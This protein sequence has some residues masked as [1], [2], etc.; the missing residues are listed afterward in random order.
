[1]QYIIEDEGEAQ[2]S[3]FEC[4]YRA[5]RRRELTGLLELHGFDD[6]RWKMPDETGFYQPVVIAR[7]V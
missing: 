6:V 1:M 4:Q 5:V 7:K 3:K 2:L